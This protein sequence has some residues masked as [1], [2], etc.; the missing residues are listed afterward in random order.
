[1]TKQELIEG[2]RFVFNNESHQVKIGSDDIRSAEVFFKQSG[3]TWLTGFKIVFN[4]QLIHSS[5]TFSAMQKMLNKLIEKW[6]LEF[7]NTEN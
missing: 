5:K 4:G 7:I 3:E 2:K 1:M 6:N